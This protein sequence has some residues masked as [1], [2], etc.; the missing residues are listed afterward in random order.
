ML[1][2]SRLERLTIE[3]HSSLLGPFVSKE[4]NEVFVNPHQG[5]VFTHIYSFS[6]KLTNG[7]IELEC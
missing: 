2:Y 3:K 4:E 6:S 5:T 7:P 1:V